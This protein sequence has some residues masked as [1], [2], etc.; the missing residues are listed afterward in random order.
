MA[1]EPT[2]RLHWTQRI[3]LVRHNL[4]SARRTN[5]FSFFKSLQAHAL[6]EGTD[7]VA[8]LYSSLGDNADAVLSTLDN[9]NAGIAYVHQDAFKAVYDGAKATMHGEQSLSSR[10]ASLRVDVCQQRDMADHAIDKTTNS[11]INL[12]HAQPAYCQDAVANAWVTGT[13]IIADAVCVCLNEM[14]KIED[15]LDDF[16]SLEYS[17]NCIQSSV[18]ASISALRGIFSLMAVPTTTNSPFLQQHGRNLSVVSA[19]SDHFNTSPNNHSRS[20]STASAFSFIKRA[21]SHSQI[22]APVLARTGRSNSMALSVSPP[23]TTGRGFRA[24]MSAACPTKMS[25]FGNYPHTILT[26]IPPTPMAMTVEEGNLSP[27]KQTKDYFAFDIG[28]QSEKSDTKRNSVEDMM[29]HESLD[30]LFSPTLDGVKMPH[31]L[32]RRR[33]SDPY[34]NPASPIAV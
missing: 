20:S 33:M 11:A 19:N 23:D 8:L 7:H 25:T 22:Q 3:A 24:S 5:D 31:T 13:T 29:Q 30:P 26:T 17:W 2:H 10:R 21:L 9:L 28:K 12:I 4:H 14:I 15:S 16:I 34:L 32:N 27:F 18:D 6:I 1:S